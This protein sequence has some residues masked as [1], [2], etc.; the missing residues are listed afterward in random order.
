MAELEERRAARHEEREDRRALAE[1]LATLNTGG[2]AQ[3]RIGLAAKDFRPFDGQEDGAAYILELTHLLGAH[4]VPVA[5]WARE[6]NLKLS[7]KAANWYAAKFPDFPAGSYPPWSDLYAGMLLAYSQSY[8]AAGAY[9]TL[10][11]LKRLPGSSGKEAYARVEEHSML[12][13]RKG[14]HNPGPEEQYAYIL[15]NQLTTEESARWTS[16]A[17]ANENV[18]DAALNE[19]ELRTADAPAGRLSCPP[20]RREAF[21]AVRREHLRN[22]LSEQGPATTG[23]RSLGPPS[24]QAAVSTGTPEDAAPGVQVPAPTSGPLPHD[25]Q[26]KVL[27]AKWTARSNRDGPPPMYSRD[28]AR[29]EAI[30]AARTANKECYGCDMHGE[31]VPNQPHWECKLHGV[32][33]S[34]E[35]KSKRVPGSGGKG[36]ARHH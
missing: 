34:A 33:A 32:G 15:Q 26:V 7:C 31:L 27:Q 19:L 1:Q 4:Q 23:G 35:S 30:F 6:L 14:V 17:N 28:R 3:Y 2:R 5:M 12:L 29:N 18:S 36:G 24:A 10:H 16:L 11:S 21:F 25:A 13:R 8:G 20:P 22:F 9:Q